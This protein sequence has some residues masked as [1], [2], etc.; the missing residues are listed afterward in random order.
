[1][2][3]MGTYGLAAAVVVAALLQGCAGARAV[4]VSTGERVAVDYVCRLS[5]GS[6]AATNMKD[7][8]QG[9]AASVLY[10][11][12]RSHE[13]LVLAAGVVPEGE[14]KALDAGFEDAVRARLTAAVVGMEPGRENRTVLTAEVLPHRTGAERF[15]DVARVRRRAVEMTVSAGEFE[16]RKGKKPESGDTFTIDPTFPGTVAEVNGDKV[17]IRFRPLS[18]PTVPTP[19]GPGTVKQAGDRYE[20]EIDAAVGRLVRTG[21]L[22]GRI[23]RVTDTTLTI[24]YGHPFGGEELSCRVRV[25]RMPDAVATRSAEEKGDVKP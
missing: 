22:V 23:S 10:A 7:A 3:H 4:P 13:P 2:I 5:D 24:D 9:A 19:Y 14:T 17:T 20:V 1:M 25:E 15:L 6:L 12:P 16:A 18:E 8:E 11:R 21:P